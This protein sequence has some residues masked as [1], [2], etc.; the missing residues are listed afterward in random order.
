MVD[1]P[2]PQLKKTHTMAHVGRPWT[3]HKPPAAA[4]IWAVIEGFGRF[5]VLCSA[6]ELGVFDALVDGPATADDLAERLGVSAPHL[7]TLLEGVVAMGLLDRRFRVFELNDTARRYL[8]SDAPASMAALLP[9]SPGP[10]ANWSTLT[11]TVRSGA[12]A[13]PID[14]DPAAFYVPLVEGTFTTINRCAMRADLQLRYSVL[15]RLRL[16]DLGA[17]G[18]PWSVAV[19]EANANATAVVNDLEGVIGV[20]RRELGSRDLTDR[21]EFRPGDFH[22]IELEREH[23]DLVVLGHICRTEGVERTRSLITRAFESLRPG[24]RVLIG[25]YFADEQRSQAGHALMMG[26]TMMASTRRGAVFTHG[27]VGEWLVEAGFEAVRMIEPIGFQEVV[28]ATRPTIS[29]GTLPHDTDQ[30]GPT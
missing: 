20:A 23:F 16:L 9:V 28:V 30:G 7:E 29:T 15:D 13:D 27:Q 8:L 14:D 18:A 21:V 22:E 5:H 11:D 4:P 19:L 3:D 10:L 12:P 17:G 6:V 25:D 26:V 24:G 1:S 2:Y